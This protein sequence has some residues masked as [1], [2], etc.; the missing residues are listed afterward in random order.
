MLPDNVQDFPS[1]SPSGK[2][3][4]GNGNS[5]NG[6]LRL[7]ELAVERIDERMKHMPTKEDLQEIKTLISDRESAMLKWLIGIVAVSLIAV[8]VALI[9]TFFD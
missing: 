7:V 5:G 6:R 1:A 3:R 2:R 9:R 8:L 4:S